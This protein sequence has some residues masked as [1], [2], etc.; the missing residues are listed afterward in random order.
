VSPSKA[1]AE[2]V[3][4]MLADGTTSD[5]DLLAKLDKLMSLSGP[6]PPPDPTPA[7]APLPA[8]SPP[9]AQAWSPAPV[10]RCKLT[11]TNPS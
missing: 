6:A 7:Q 4:R 8:W 11:L 3:H 5:M 2:G 9:P 10:G 1:E